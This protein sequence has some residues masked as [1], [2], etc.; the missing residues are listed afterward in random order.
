MAKVLLLTIESNTDFQGFISGDI[1]LSDKPRLRCS[2]HFD[3]ATL[4]ELVEYYPCQS[5]CELALDCKTS[6]STICSHLKSNRFSFEAEKWP[7][8]QE[9]QFRWWK[10]GILWQSSMQ[11]LVDWQG[12]ISAAYSKSRASWKKL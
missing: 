3:Q 11:K 2:S 6:Q 12:W 5:I 4:K 8:F 9:Y 1:S 7:I 10:M